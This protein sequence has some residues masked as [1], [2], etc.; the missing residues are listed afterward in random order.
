MNHDPAKRRFIVG[1]IFVFITVSFIALMGFWYMGESR[2][3]ARLDV[4]RKVIKVTVDSIAGGISAGYFQWTSM[5]E[6]IRTG[7]LAFLGEYVEEI[8][9]LYPAVETIYL[10][11]EIPDFEGIYFVDSVGKKICIHFR[12]FD[13]N[14]SESIPDIQAIAVIDAQYLMKAF[15]FG[16]F[17]LS[18][19]GLPLLW[20]LRVKPPF[21][22]TWGYLV[23]TFSTGVLVVLLV[24]LFAW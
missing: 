7:D 13:D 1:I 16:D 15:N 2:N 5:Y 21:P 3:K 14:L 18:S 12:I 9:S 19:D 8:R 20:E 4:I 17:R 24:I 22:L 11:R 6:A 10:K 23:S